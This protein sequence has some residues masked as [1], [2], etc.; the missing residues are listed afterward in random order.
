MERL[1]PGNNPY[2]SYY[3]QDCTLEMNE[4]LRDLK[5]PTFNFLRF[6]QRSGHL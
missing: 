1:P 5:N 2:F 4:A 6:L 3:F